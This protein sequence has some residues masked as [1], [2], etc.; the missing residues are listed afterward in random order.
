MIR[1][2]AKLDRLWTPEWRSL[3]HLNSDSTIDT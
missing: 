2:Q 3:S 1:V